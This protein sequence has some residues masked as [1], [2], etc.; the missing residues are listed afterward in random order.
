MLESSKV[1]SLKVYVVWGLWSYL[2]LFRGSRWFLIQNSIIKSCIQKAR[3]GYLGIS[4]RQRWKDTGWTGSP[5]SGRAMRHAELKNDQRESFWNGKNSHEFYDQTYLT[6]RVLLSESRHWLGI[7]LQGC[8]LSLED[9]LAKKQHDSPGN[10]SEHQGQNG[11]GS[12]S[13]HGPM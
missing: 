8:G 2:C 7:D 4:V 11:R 3:H 9:L 1:Q 13:T 6:S 12:G 5:C 10:K